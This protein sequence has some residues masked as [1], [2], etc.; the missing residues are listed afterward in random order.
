METAAWSNLSIFMH[1]IYM[2]CINDSRKILTTVLVPVSAA[3]QSFTLFSGGGGLSDL[4]KL[5]FV[6]YIYISIEGYFVPYTH[7]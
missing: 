6:T 4:S 2:V 3:K 7:A 5:V 1:N